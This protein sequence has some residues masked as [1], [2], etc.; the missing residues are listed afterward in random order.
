MKNWA[1]C[2]ERLQEWSK[3]TAPQSVTIDDPDAIDPE[4]ICA[5]H[6]FSSHPGDPDPKR[7]SIGN[8]IAAVPRML[9]F[10]KNAYALLNE[11][12]SALCD[13]AATLEESD[14][15]EAAQVRTLI[16]EILGEQAKAAEF[17]GLLRSCELAGL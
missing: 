16:S 9:A 15:A 1:T 8:A 4:Q 17:C 12:Q 14:V 7:L 3:Q 5:L 11:A 6:Q 10:C 13:H 2:T